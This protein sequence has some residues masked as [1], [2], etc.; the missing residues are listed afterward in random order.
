MSI[1]CE[2]QPPYLSSRWWGPSAPPTIAGENKSGSKH[3]SSRQMGQ[4]IR[5]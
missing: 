1:L 3:R 2:V 4:E 5:E